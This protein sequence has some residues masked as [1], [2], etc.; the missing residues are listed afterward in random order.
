MIRLIE[1]NNYR[2]LRYIR[3]TLDDFQI[4]V[5]P[6]ASGKTTFLDVVGFLCDLLSDGLDTAIAKRSTNIK[7]LMFNH[8]GDRFE[9]AV[10][11]APPEG[12]CDPK[13]PLI[14]YEISVGL[15]YESEEY[16]IFDEQVI[17]KQDNHQHQP[18]TQR[19][20]FP[21][22][23][24]PPDTIMHPRQSGT[25]NKRIV[26]KVYDGNDNYYAEHGKKGKGGWAPS[27]R[28][29]PRKSAL[30]NMPEDETRFPITTW[31]RD[32]LVNGTQQIML[33]STALR[34]SSRPGLGLLFQPDGSNLPWVI[35]DLRNTN[36]DLF[37]QWIEQLQTALSDIVDIQTTIMPDTR[38]RYLQIIYRD[39]LKVPSWTASDG[40]LRMLA[41]TLPAFLPDFHG[42]YLI[43]EPEN[44]I[45][46]MAMETVFQCLS[47]VYHA[48]ILL[49]THSPIILGA[50][51]TD[52]ILCFK[53]DN[54]G[55]TDTVRGSDHPNLKNWQD[56]MLLSEMHASGILG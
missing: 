51:Q 13:Y 14:R 4:L 47:S 17:L 10:E 53:K 49:A 25:G 11:M 40:T 12:R 29:G 39:G 6:N 3:Q 48:Q 34:Q 30:A 19:L 23:P 5:G 20:L 37:R 7:D 24:T 31:L 52:Q 35:D 32:T 42:I 44:G 33:N 18:T 2:C 1:A 8:Q 50:A 36:I 43:E 27:I 15:D 41:L 54:T 55:A 9:L 38:H 21:G 28:L 22:P 46:P 45:H 56:N 26:R 16:H